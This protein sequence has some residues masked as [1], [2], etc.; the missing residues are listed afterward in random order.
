MVDAETDQQILQ[1]ILPKV[2]GP[3][4]TPERLI[5]TLKLLDKTDLHEAMMVILEKSHFRQLWVAEKAL[6]K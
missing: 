2:L 3:R 1:H 4:A 5:H 6:L